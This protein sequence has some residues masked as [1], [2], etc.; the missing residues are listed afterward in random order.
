LLEGYSPEWDPII[1]RCATLKA[2]VVE[3]DPH[4][5]TGLRAILNFGHTVGHAVE[6][7]G[8]YTAYLHGEAISIGMFVAGYLS[9]H[10]TG[11]SDIERIRL[12]TLLTKVG[13]PAGVKKPIPRPTLM[14]YLAR[15]K[16]AAQGNVKFVLLKGLGKAVS[17]QVVSE[18]ILDAA[19]RTSG[20]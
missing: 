12:G 3:K 7:A 10:L 1:S 6:A 2:K 16:K 8:G 18:E 17:G 14:N 9:C 5:L 19:L 11:F 4:E 15:D 13:L 20:L